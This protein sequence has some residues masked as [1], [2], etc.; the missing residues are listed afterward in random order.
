LGVIGEFGVPWHDREWRPVFDRFL[1]ELERRGMTACAWAGGDMWGD[2]ILS[3]HLGPG[4]GGAA[5][6][7]LFHQVWLRARSSASASPRPMSLR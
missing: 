2:Y 7:S 1:V 3:L 5:G 6:Q 4:A